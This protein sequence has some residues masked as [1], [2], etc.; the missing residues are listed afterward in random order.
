MKKVLMF[1]CLQVIVFA[2]FAQNEPILMTIGNEKVSVAEFERIYKKNNFQTDSLNNQKKSVDEYIDLFINFKLKVIEAEHLGLDTSGAFKAELN[3][4]RKQLVKPYLVDQQVIDK[5]VAEGYERMKNEVHASH[6]LI[7]VDDNAP[8]KDTLVAYNKAMSIRDRIAKGEDFGKVAEETSEDPSAKVNKGDLGF[9]TAFQMVYPFEEFCFMHKAGEVSMPVRTQYGYHIIKLIE[10]RPYQGKVKVAHIMFTFEKPEEAK[11]AEK[12]I[13]DLYQKLNDG[14]DFNKLAEEF[15]QDKNT[16]RNGGE[17]QWFGTG[18]LMVPEFENAAFA[19]K[20]AG[21]ISEPVKTSFSYHVIKLLDRKGLEPFDKMKNELRSKLSRDART[22]KGKGD[23]VKKLKE[24]YKYRLFTTQEIKK[25]KVVKETSNVADFYAVVDT[26][27]FEGKWDK[28]KA[29]NLNKPLFQ[30]MDSVYNQKDFTE[31]LGKIRNKSAKRDVNQ[32]VDEQYNK[33]VDEVILKLEDSRLEIKYPDFRYLMQEYHDGILLFDLTD[34]MVWSKA[35]KDTVGLQSYYDT[36]KEGYKWTKR[37]EASIYQVKNIEIGKKA[38]KMF[39]QIEKKKITAQEILDKLNKKDSTAIHL[40]ESKIYSK[41]DNK[42]I[43]TIYDG[44]EKKTI[45]LTASVVLMPS[46]NTLVYITKKL[47]PMVKTL[48]EARG[49]VTAD[50]QNYLEQEW[51]KSLR[52][53][54]PVLVN[55]EQLNIL[56]K[57]EK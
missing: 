14:G 1:F 16:A 31:F 27:I 13:R 25:K 29:A 54:Y 57:K 28:S 35:V 49:L 46:S 11:E 42:L 52:N 48:Q 17:L 5:L 50:Y 44:I 24:E 30:L 40:V 26:M 6:I 18:E 56:R 43:D 12:N 15:S 2:L 9:F 45:P 36:N 20:N 32:F 3:G 41:D 23:I 21:D 19:L 33:F 8:A 34:R 47:D 7:K 37:L 4:Y 10:T 51:I 53:K 55:D 38:E 39:L 22:E